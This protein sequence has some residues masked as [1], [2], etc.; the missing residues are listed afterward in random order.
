MVSG[1][2][3][4]SLAWE[5]GTPASTDG[6]GLSFPLPQFSKSPKT[7]VTGHFFLRSSP[8]SLMSNSATVGGIS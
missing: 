5:Q 2:G 6:G 1:R 8:Q 7:Q 3:G 4:R